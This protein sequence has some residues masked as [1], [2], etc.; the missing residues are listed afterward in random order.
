MTKIA[1]KGNNND[2]QKETPTERKVT[3]NEN[4][5]KRRQME[6]DAKTKERR[7]QT[8][9]TQSE[10]Q[11]SSS[12]PIQFERLSTNAQHSLATLHTH[13]CEHQPVTPAQAASDHRPLPLLP[14][15]GPPHSPVL[16][17]P[18]SQGCD[19]SAACTIASTVEGR[20]PQT[21]GGAAVYCAVAKGNDTFQLLSAGQQ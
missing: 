16:P 17:L 18:P 2:N 1:N 14:P 10:Q 7:K 20:M 21:V 11:I 6:T 5:G 8:Q 13:R 3:S 19:T 12:A 9:A 4:A 15:H